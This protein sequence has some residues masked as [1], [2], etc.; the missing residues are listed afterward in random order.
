MSSTAKALSACESDVAVR[1]HI[2]QPWA[3]GLTRVVATLRD[4]APY[5]AIE[6]VLP[7]GS[8]MA[9]LLWL[10]RRQKSSVCP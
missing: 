1:R 7:G 6:I 9:F 3:N 10:Y 5:A 8:L 4:L 2:F